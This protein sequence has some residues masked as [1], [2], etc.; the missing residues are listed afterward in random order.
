MLRSLIMLLDVHD[1]IGGAINLLFLLNLL[2]LWKKSVQYVIIIMNKAIDRIALFIL[3]GDMIRIAYAPDKRSTVL[4][5][6]SSCAWALY[7]EFSR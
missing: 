7:R 6:E 1:F 4:L 2:F 3:I 5:Y